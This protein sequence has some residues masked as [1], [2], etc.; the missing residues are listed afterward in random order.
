MSI[1]AGLNIIGE[2]IVDQLV[3]TLD[4]QGHRA[5]GE[6]QETM[7]HEVKRTGSGFDII[8]YAKDYAKY[9]DKGIPSGVW[10]SVYALMEWIETKGIVTGEREVKS[11][12]FAIRR[13]IFN[14]GSPTKGSLKFSRTGKRDEFIKVMLDAN[15]KI[16]FEKVTQLFTDQMTLS[17]ENTIRENKQIF[18]S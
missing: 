11:L 13:T 8:I 2:F 4:E 5:S 18:E 12:A 1:P 15:A 6:L 10:V 16:I 3:K 17:L 9:V 14:E 7:R